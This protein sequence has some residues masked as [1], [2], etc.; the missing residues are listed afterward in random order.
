MKMRKQTQ[1]MKRIVLGLVAMAIGTSNIWA[2]KTQL[3][4]T[5][6]K[7]EARYTEQLQTLK[8]AIE[9]ALPEVDEQRKA[10]YLKA[11]EAEKVATKNLKA[12]KA[13][14]GELKKAKGLV[15]HGHWWIN[16]A[17]KNIAQAKAQLK[18]ATTETERQEAQKTITKQQ[19]RRDAGIKALKERKARLERAKKDEPRLIKERK[20]AKEAYA[21][22][23]AN[24]MEAFKQLGL[25]SLLA[26]NKM[27]PKLAKYVVLMEATPRGLAVFAQQGK[28]QEKLIARLLADADLM[29]Q[30]LVADGAEN[31]Q[32][33]Q[34]VQ[35]YN[36]ILNTSKKVKNG[37]LQRLALAISLEHAVPISQRNP[38]AEKD[39]PKTV[40]PVHRYLHYEKAFL[41]DEL[42]PA[43]KDLSVWEYRMV[44]DGH[45]PDETLAW[46]RKMLRTYRPD[47]IMTDDYRW[48]YVALVRTEVRYGSQYNKY[49]KPELQFF[50]NI[51]MNGGVCGRR[52]F[53]GRFILRAFGIP[54]TARPSPGHGALAHW[55]PDGWVVCLGG[56]WGA[57][58]T[59]TRYHDDLDFLATTQARESEKYVQVKRAQWI[60]DVLGEKRVFGF[61]SG[62]PG[63][64]YG[65]SLYRQRSIIEELEA[66]ALEAVG[67]ELGEANESDVSYNFVSPPVTEEDRKITVDEN[68]VI[69]I[70]AAACSKPTK[71]TGKIIFM[72]SNLGGKQLHYS[73]NGKQQEFEYTFEA[74]SAG[75]YAL[76]ARIAN[77]SWGQHLMVAVNG[78]E[79]P[80]DIKLPLT[81]ALW[82]TTEPVQITLDKGKNVLTFSRAGDNIRG[83]TI[84]D[85][86]L[87][88]V[89]E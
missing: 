20:A 70:P 23:K 83:L 27:D 42:D 32:Y 41:N 17:K 74:P 50:Q 40:D 79:T 77:P 62:N 65:V 29:Q 60:G 58:S 4:E 1:T 75:T 2:A 71:S 61:R 45:E 66:V 81:L 78:A 25:K 12:A 88:P 22:A 38:K 48:R 11:R 28:K 69:T 85:F 5:G 8:T 21:Q 56:G 37:T 35:I 80:I 64:W 16:S 24:T 84:K 67:K 7:L 76:T 57:G 63:F 3:T 47:H 55:T 26:S 31:G 89:K 51:L 44:V 9:K 49:D 46:G 82:D 53:I 54:T 86:T 59:K 36:E 52:A 10:A 6:K 13:A 73:R 33:G 14:F 34:A 18:K 87:T 72:K 19:D 30:M 43:F 68:G 39:A 15:N